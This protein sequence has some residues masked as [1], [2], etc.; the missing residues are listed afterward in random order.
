MKVE[1]INPFIESVDDLFTTMLGCRAERG[2]VSV[3]RAE[4]PGQDLTAIIGLS[5]PVRGTVALA[6]PAE[7]ARAMVARM[8]GSDADAVAESLSDGLA[9]LVNIVAGGAKARLNGGEGPIIDLSLPTVV[10]GRSHG[11]DHLSHSVWLDVPFG[12]ELGRFTLRVTFQQAGSDSGRG[13]GAE[14]GRN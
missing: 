5:G 4:A 1:H 7:T 9:E 8:T 12:S 14:G 6:F 13:G 3:L 2:Q 11:L 10:R